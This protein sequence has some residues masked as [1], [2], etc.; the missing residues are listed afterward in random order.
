MEMLG[1]GGYDGAG[2]DPVL[3]ESRLNTQHQRVFALMMD[4]KWRTLQG[5]ENFTRFPQASISATL[6]DFRKAR[7]GN[8]TVDRRRKPEVDPHKGLFEYRLVIRLDPPQL[9]QLKL[10]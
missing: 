2:Y 8:H 3:D 10:F 6:R 4:G 7:Y 5:I 1:R 9:P